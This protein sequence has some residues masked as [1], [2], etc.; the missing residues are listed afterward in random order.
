M[1]ASSAV[2]PNELLTAYRQ[3]TAAGEAYYKAGGKVCGYFGT[4]MPIEIA[5]A[6]GHMPMA[7]MPLPERPTPHAEEWL[8]STFDPQLRLILDQLIS[9]EL[10][11]VD[12]AVAVSQSSPDS[13]VFLAAREILRQGFGNDIPPLHHYSLLGLKS[14][15]VRD[16]GRME[17]HN[18]ANR[19]RSNSG[20][21]A[22]APRLKSAIEL[23]N[24]IRRQWRLLDQRRHEGCISGTDAL[25]LIAPSHFMQPQDYLAGL[26]QALANLKP[27]PAAG[28]RLVLMSSVALSDTRLHEAIEA[29]GSTVIGESDFWGAC[30]ATPDIDAGEDPL[31][32]IY[33]HYYNHVPNRSVYPAAARLNWFYANAAAADVDGVMIH[34]P[35]SD[36]SLGWD[37]PRLCDFLE[38]HKKLFFMTRE[39]AATAEGRAAITQETAKFAKRIQERTK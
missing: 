23:T 36:R 4:G 30:C 20:Q 22:T 24:A 13:A 39:D 10:T 6:T 8:N 2:I 28:P 29:G 1:A 19:L 31:D 26:T 17:I 12:L 38:Q 14:E 7:I 25:T 27:R 33:M 15:A 9:G 35:R 16:Y 34:M 3:R 11:F 21:E 5:L 32:A 37:Y 18:L